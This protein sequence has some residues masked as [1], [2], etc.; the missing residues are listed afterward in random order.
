MKVK[1]VI[2]NMEKTFGIL[3][4]AG[5]SE[6]KQKRVNGRMETTSRIY[7]LYSNIQRSDNIEVTIPAR[8]GEKRFEYKQK[9]KLINPRITA[10]GR[11]IGDSGVTDYILLA[12]DIVA[13]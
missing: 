11:K 12:D 8:A 9:V 10:E 1:C 6:V 13:E 2:P 7:N 5:E 4:F 3:K